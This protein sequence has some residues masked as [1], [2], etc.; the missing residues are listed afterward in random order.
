M[1][2]RRARRRGRRR[3]LIVGAAIGSAAARRGN[4]DNDSDQYD[5]VDTQGDSIAELERLAE[6]RDRGALTEEEFS[7]EKRQ[8]LGL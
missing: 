5:Q 4:T 1:G 6:L 2:M 7:A 8:L 3:G